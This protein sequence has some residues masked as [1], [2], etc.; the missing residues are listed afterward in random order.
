M[1]LLATENDSV[2]L[3]FTVLELLALKNSLNE[4]CH[5]LNM[6]NFL[7][8][9]GIECVDGKALLE[10]FFHLHLSINSPVESTERFVQRISIHQDYVTVSLT[11]T[12]LRVLANSLN[13]VYIRLD[14]REF[15][16]RM[17]VN[18]DDV[19]TLM[20]EISQLHNTLT[21]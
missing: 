6:P 7:C 14:K 8:S 4:V 13:E 5:G 9:I 18:R 19:F 21:K 12:V 10:E 20:Q 2:T 11:S 17:R 16:T 15:L 3:S 1:E